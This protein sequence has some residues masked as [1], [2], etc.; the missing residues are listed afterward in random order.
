MAEEQ[1][2]EKA[3]QT[4]RNDIAARV[5]QLVAMADAARSSG[6]ALDLDAVRQVLGSE[7][8]L[9]AV[10]AMMEANVRGDLDNATMQTALTTALAQQQLVDGQTARIVEELKAATPAKTDEAKVE[11]APAAET[12]PEAPVAEKPAVEATA[13]PEQ[14]INQV[15]A[16]REELKAAIKP[17]QVAAKR[18][19]LA[20]KP[21]SVAS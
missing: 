2:K 3:E 8:M 5:A 20:G 12:K 21:R 6:N 11:A 16:K 19:E 13:A 10:V 14:P 7:A 15:A 1:V 18:A 4:Q 9:D 17:D